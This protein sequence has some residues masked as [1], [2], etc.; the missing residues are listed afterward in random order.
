MSALHENVRRELHRLPPESNADSF[1]WM[2]EHAKADHTICDKVSGEPVCAV[3]LAPR[4]HMAA[5]NAHIIEESVRMLAAALW[6]SDPEG[7][8]AGSEEA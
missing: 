4:W 7:M 3:Y 2:A 8:A 1:R 5:E 6:E